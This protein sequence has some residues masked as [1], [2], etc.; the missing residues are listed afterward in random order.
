MAADI[1]LV[2]KVF[3]D[4]E[5]VKEV[6]VLSD[7]VEIQAVLKAKGIDLS[8]EE[9]QKIGDAVKKMQAENPGGELSLDQLDEV[10]GGSIIVTIGYAVIAVI[11]ATAFLW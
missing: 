4:E 7:P 8:I 2:K 9:I 3:S 5:F 6:A 1:N 10:A 11:A